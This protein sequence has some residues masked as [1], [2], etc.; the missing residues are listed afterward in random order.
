MRYSPE[1]FLFKLVFF[2]FYSMDVNLKYSLIIFNLFLSR[3]DSG[4]ELFC[5]ERTIVEATYLRLHEIA[6]DHSFRIKN[7]IISGFEMKKALL[8]DAE[9]IRKR[10]DHLADNLGGFSHIVNDDLEVYDDLKTF[11]CEIPM[12]VKGTWQMIYISNLS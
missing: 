11:L 1:Y 5:N 6:I 3:I 12:K 7:L 9:S 8:K 10:Q 2:L 4:H